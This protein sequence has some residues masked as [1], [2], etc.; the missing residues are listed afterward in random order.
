MS[1]EIAVKVR[2]R[3]TH[4]YV[5]ALEDAEAPAHHGRQPGQRGPERKGWCRQVRRRQ[6]AA[7]AHDGTKVCF[8]SDAFVIK[9]RQTHLNVLEGGRLLLVVVIIFNENREEKAGQEVPGA[10][11]DY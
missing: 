7:R 11:R 4:L 3:E 10:Y 6:R 5:F 9:P 1:E 8:V 2:R